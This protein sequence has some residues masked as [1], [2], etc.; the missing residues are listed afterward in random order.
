MFFNYTRVY[1]RKYNVSTFGPEASNANNFRHRDA[2][3][4]GQKCNPEAVK[5]AMECLMQHR[6]VQKIFRFM[7]SVGCG[8]FQRMDEVDGKRV[9]A[10]AISRELRGNCCS[11]MREHACTSLRLLADDCQ[12]V[13]HTDQCVEVFR[14][15]KRLRPKDETVE[16]A[17]EAWTEWRYIDVKPDDP[18][19]QWKDGVW[20]FPEDPLTKSRVEL[21]HPVPEVCQV[22][23]S[24]KGV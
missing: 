19:P 21:S 8:V 13:G 6:H 7:I 4:V 20:F 3:N 23:P 12:D 15:L 11:S 24:L 9:L 10:E 1:I 14:M 2:L 16:V 17:F 22:A 18:Y 5:Y